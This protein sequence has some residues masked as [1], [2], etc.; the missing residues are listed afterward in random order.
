MY[1]YI[2]FHPFY[3]EIGVVDSLKLAKLREL[4]AGD[5]NMPSVDLANTPLVPMV[6]LN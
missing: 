1:F 4:T 2:Q 6:G 5:W 3:R